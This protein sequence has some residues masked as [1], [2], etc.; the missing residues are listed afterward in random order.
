M[1]ACDVR[2]RRVATRGWI[3][4]TPRLVLDAVGELNR[5]SV[6]GLLLTALHKGG[7]VEG[8]DPALIEDVGEEFGT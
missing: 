4:S 2:D 1:I 5:L 8:T 7:R 3:R 6:S